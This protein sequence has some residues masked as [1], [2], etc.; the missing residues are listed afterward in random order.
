MLDWNEPSQ[1]LQSQGLLGILDR[2]SSQCLF[3][4]AHETF[5]ENSRGRAS[6][7]IPA[8]AQCKH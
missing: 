6:V 3:P 8:V 1:E 5:L 4:W 2:N 7:I